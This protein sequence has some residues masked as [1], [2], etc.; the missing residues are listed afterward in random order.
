MVAIPQNTNTTLHVIEHGEV[1]Q[2][3]RPYLGMSSL[4]HSCPRYLWYAFRWC[5]TEYHTP[6][7]LRLFNRGHREEPAMIEQLN[8]KGIRFWGAQTEFTCAHGHC[9]G[10][11]DGF[12]DKVIE[13]PKTVHLAEFKTISDTYMKKLK[14]DGVKLYSPAYYGQTQIYMKHANLTRCLFMAVNKNDDEYYIERIR[15]DE[16]YAANLERK[17]ENIILSEGPPP[18]QFESTWFECKWCAAKDICHNGM[19]V[20]HNCRTCQYCDLCPDGKWECSHIGLQ[21]TTS[22]QRLEHKCYERLHT[23]PEGASF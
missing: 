12:C 10:H 1:A 23:I 16:N 7:K 11:C 17:A 13:A 8:R 18:K 5:Y 19:E 9:L 14:K 20:D 2:V 21:I 22:M 4:G 15:Y 6:R 3:T